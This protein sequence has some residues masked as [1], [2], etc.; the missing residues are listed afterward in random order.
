MGLVDYQLRTGEN[1]TLKV[2]LAI[3]LMILLV[4]VLLTPAIGFG[5]GPLELGIWLG[6]ILL[7]LVLPALQRAMHRRQRSK[8][9]QT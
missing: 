3:L 6:L 2:Q 7:V 4:P 9:V 5:V 1:M 8:T